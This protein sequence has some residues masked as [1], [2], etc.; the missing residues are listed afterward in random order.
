M[1]HGGRP[2]GRSKGQIESGQSVSLRA[3]G[4]E[5][6]QKGCRVNLPRDFR[7]FCEQ[8][9]HIAVGSVK[10]ELHTDTWRFWGRLAVL[11]ASAS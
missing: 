3:W 8:R 2:I 7:K 4:Q 9:L 10:Q 11:Q 5:K 1:V 6:L